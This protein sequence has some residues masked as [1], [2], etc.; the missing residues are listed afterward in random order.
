MRH[1]EVLSAAGLVTSRKRGRERWHY[2]NAIPLERMY[3]RWV[4]AHA[5]HWAAG[6][7]RI[8]RSVESTPARMSAN[9]YTAKMARK[10]AKMVGATLW[11]QRGSERPATAPPDQKVKS[12]ES[13][14]KTYSAGLRN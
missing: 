5:G 4:E 3:E 12:A 9:R 14:N 11:V 1:L 13:T 10:M 8:R 2:L 6:L 7:L